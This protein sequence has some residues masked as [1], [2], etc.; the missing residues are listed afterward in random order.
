MCPKVYGIINKPALASSCQHLGGGSRQI[1]EFQ[2]TLSFL[3]YRGSS[4][5]AGA[6]KTK[7]QKQQMHLGVLCMPNIT[8]KLGLKFIK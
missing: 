4:K 2:A 8:V 5:S 3:V 7:I 1:P 6:L